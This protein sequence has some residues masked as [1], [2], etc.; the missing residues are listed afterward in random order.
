MLS[1]KC[2]GVFLKFFVFPFA[3]GLQKFFERYTWILPDEIF[4]VSSPAV[5]LFALYHFNT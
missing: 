5:M 1:D 3:I 4:H 2:F